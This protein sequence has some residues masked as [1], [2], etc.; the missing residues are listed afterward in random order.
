VNKGNYGREECV[1]TVGGKL[2]SRICNISLD[3]NALDRDGSER[4][5]LVD[6]L[7]LREANEINFVIAGS[8]CRAGSLK[9]G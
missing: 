8:V 3:A 6:R 1:V 5:V 7:A 4:D 2:D 9:V